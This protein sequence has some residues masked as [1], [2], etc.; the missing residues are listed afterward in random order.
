MPLMHSTS[1]RLVTVAKNNMNINI[2]KQ[3]AHTK[4]KELID[5]T[6][7]IG[8]AMYADSAIPFI[9]ILIDRVVEEVEKVVVPEKGIHKKHSDNQGWCLVCGGEKVRRGLI[10]AFN[11]FRGEGGQPKCVGFDARYASDPCDNCGQRASEHI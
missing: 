10:E 8:L 4:W 9:D 1:T 2:L 7:D 11:Q 6:G 5:A 3:D